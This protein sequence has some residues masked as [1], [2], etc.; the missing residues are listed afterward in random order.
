MPHDNK[1]R[2]AA[3]S[4]GQPQEPREDGTDSPSE[5]PQVT[6]PANTLMS[7]SRLPDL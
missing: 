5:P 4:Q 1:S 2:E 6:Y 3:A 7:D